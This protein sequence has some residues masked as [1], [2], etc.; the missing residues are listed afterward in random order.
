MKRGGMKLKRTI[1]LRFRKKGTFRSANNTQF[2]EKQ[3][4]SGSVDTGL[5]RWM[6]NY[7]EKIQI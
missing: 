7:N 5:S 1:A 6:I 3:I 4:F 2:G